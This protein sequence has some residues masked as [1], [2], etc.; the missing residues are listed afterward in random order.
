M[1]HPTMTQA[2]AAE[3]ATDMQAQA[4]AARRAREARRGRRPGKPR[5]LTAAAMLL[6]HVTSPLRPVAR[7]SALSRPS[8][9]AGSGRGRQ[10]VQGGPDA[11]GGDGHGSQRQAHLDPA[12]HAG[13]GQVA[14]VA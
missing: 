14:E 12:Q 11:A 4:A 9:L 1:H 5:L 2:I 13:Q 3:R 6:S 8:R 7:P 10:V